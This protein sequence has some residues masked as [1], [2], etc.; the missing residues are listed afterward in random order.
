M[1]DD[2]LSEKIPRRNFLQILAAAGAQMAAQPGGVVATA[3]RTLT[4][5]EPLRLPQILRDSI[6]EQLGAVVAPPHS[7]DVDAIFA[8]MY[9]MSARCIGRSYMSE[10]TKEIQRLL[11]ESFGRIMSIDQV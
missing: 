8:D 2:I 10:A 11:S 9:E 4:A 7:T 1:S 3:T 5:G 6:L